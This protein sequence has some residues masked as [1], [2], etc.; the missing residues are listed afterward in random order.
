MIGH[1]HKLMQQI[2]FLRA[3]VEQNIEKQTRHS[4]RLKELLLL[5]GARGDEV[6]SRSGVAF[7]VEPPSRTSAA[8]AGIGTSKVIAALKALRHPKSTSG[9]FS[10]QPVSR[11]SLPTLSPRLTCAPPKAAGTPAQPE[12]AIPFRNTEV[13]RL[14]LPVFHLQNISGVGADMSG[15]QKYKKTK[16]FP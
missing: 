2:F 4:L 7:G 12:T 14:Y 1:H 11:L 5:K 3:V 13:R 6:S 15:T 9:R 16:K 10:Q 8:K